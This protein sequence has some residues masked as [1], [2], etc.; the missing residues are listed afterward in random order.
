MVTTWTLLATLTTLTLSPQDPTPPAKPESK[1]SAPDPAA[2]GFY[3]TAQ[4][5]GLRLR[6]GD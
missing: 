4:S 2:T 3:Q 1:P 6:F 5:A